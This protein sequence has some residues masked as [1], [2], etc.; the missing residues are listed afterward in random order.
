M[1]WALVH[2]LLNRSKV[3]DIR[4]VERSCPKLL[5][6]MQASS[7]WMNFYGHSKVSPYH[8]T[9]KSIKFCPLAALS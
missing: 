5:R 8:L 6:H 2:R 9:I 4:V 1:S 7:Y 3:C